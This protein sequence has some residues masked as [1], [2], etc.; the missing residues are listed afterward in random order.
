MTKRKK[1]GTNNKLS[2]IKGGINAVDSNIT[3]LFAGAANELIGSRVL[4]VFHSPSFLPKV[5][6]YVRPA[7]AGLYEAPVIAHA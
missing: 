2:E 7:A 3:I 1:T 6:S 5:E 4:V